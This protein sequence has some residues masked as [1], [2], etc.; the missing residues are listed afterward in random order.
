MLGNCRRT[1]IGVLTDPLSVDDGAGRDGEIG[2][3]SKAVFQR[4]ERRSRWAPAESVCEAFRH[5]GGLPRHPQ[6]SERQTATLVIEQNVVGEAGY[7]AAAGRGVREADG[8]SVTVSEEGRREGDMSPDGAHGVVTADHH[9]G[10][11][12][13]APGGDLVPIDEPHA[14]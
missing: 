4:A 7:R 11:D 12:A 1:P 8:G 3:T 2:E 10:I 5:G 14:G 13:G 9:D 6:L